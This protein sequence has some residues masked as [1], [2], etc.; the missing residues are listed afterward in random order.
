MIV[1]NLGSNRILSGSLLMKCQK[2]G[3]EIAPDVKPVHKKGYVFC[4]ENCSV[5]Y[6]SIYNVWLDT[7]RPVITPAN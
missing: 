3:A 5:Q 6:E 4:D 1:L 2:C 7:A